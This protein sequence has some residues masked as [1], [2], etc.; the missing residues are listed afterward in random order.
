MDCY[1]VD[2]NLDIISVTPMAQKEISEELWYNN[3]C[4]YVITHKSK[5]SRN[6]HSALNIQ[7]IYQI[8]VQ[9]KC[10]TE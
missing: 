6:M 10:K 2:R 5:V 9:N 4:H 1:V 3:K 8:L 7:Q